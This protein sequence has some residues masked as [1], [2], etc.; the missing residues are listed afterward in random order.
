MAMRREHYA[1]I[2]DLGEWAE[3]DF[4]ARCAR[5]GVTRNRSRQDR[6]GWDYLVE[7]PAH[8]APGRS[9]DMQPVGTSARVQVKSK[10]R[11]RPFVD[12]KLSNA[13]RLAKEPAPCFLVL[14]AASD[15]G[16][17]VRVF[18]RHFWRDEIEAALR[19]ARQADADGRGDLH[20]LTLRYSFSDDEEHTGD[21]VAWMAA[22][23][24]GHVGYV[25]EKEGLVRT[26]GF[27]EA[28]G[29]H[30]NLT[31][32]LADL[33]ALVDH[34]IGLI[35]SAPPMRVELLQR[36]FGIDAAVPI[37]AGVPDLAHLRSEPKPC[38]I[39]I[40]PLDG[41]DAWLD[42]E[43]LLP[44]LGG[45]PT[46]RMKLRVVTDILELVVAG[47]NTGRLTLHFEP[48]RRLR[49]PSHRAF[50]EILKLAAVG[51]LSLAVFQDGRA[52]MP[53]TGRLEGVEP[54][55]EVGQLSNVI[56]CLEKAMS[57]VLPAA[58]A[59]SRSE[60]DYAWNHLV[61]F[62]GLVAGTDFKGRFEL[63][64]APDRAAMRPTVAFFHGHVEIG[65]WT[66]GVVA[67]RPITCFELNAAAGVIELGPARILETIVRRGDGDGIAAE[68][69]EHYHRSVAPE[70]AAALEMLGGSW[71]ALLRFSGNS[72]V[73]KE[74]RSRSPERSG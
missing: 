51:P 52:I 64:Q 7:F 71:E 74:Q 15:G 18:A 48:G 21:L 54:D 12:L 36:R 19:R 43:L 56:A 25:V 5:A 26:V 24:S 37:F 57:G 9:A 40:R 17:P 58:F 35:E 42:G 45:L 49:L 3:D 59:V 70:K 50:V 39:R 73:A 16:E 62:N 22:L 46:E 10:A 4:S 23:V 33:D 61:D 44:G 1:P 20:K 38:R 66:I 28:L 60:I 11:G 31:F 63:R 14:Y 67:R 13:L 32:D 41:P 47:T 72:A 53:V 65:E 68:L 6:T 30:G 27:D 8:P 55:E 34:Q 29:I 2:I 69:H